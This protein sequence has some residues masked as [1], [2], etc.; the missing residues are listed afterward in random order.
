[1]T[2]SDRSWHRI[3]T[4][5]IALRHMPLEPKTLR[6][7]CG[8]SWFPDESRR[9]RFSGPAQINGIDTAAFRCYFERLQLAIAV[10]AL[11][12]RLIRC[13]KLEVHVQVLRPSGQ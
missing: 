3:V 2:L 8:P 7:P 1:M 12:H 11:D 13:V 10:S 9:R 6:K 5:A 4:F